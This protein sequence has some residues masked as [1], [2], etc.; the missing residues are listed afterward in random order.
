M[1]ANLLFQSPAGRRPGQRTAPRGSRGR[2]RGLGVAELLV[3]LA[4]GASVLAAVAYAV[5]ATFRA[6]SIN[7]QQS[8]LMQKSRLALYRLVTT[9]RTTNAHLPISDIQKLEFEA[10]SVTADVGIQMFDFNESLVLYRYVPARSELMVEITPKG[11]IKNEYVLLRGVKKFE[12]KFEP[13]RSETSVRTGGV[14]DQLKRATIL[15]TI[16]T[17]GNAADVDESVGAQEVTLSAAVM[18]RQNIW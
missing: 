12:I 11:G 2:N 8:D 15:L 6:Y 14:Y 10:G 4:I 9:L 17:A 1:N 7:Q 18:P 5:D 13:M 16:Q 3:S